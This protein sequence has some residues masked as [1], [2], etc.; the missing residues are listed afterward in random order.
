MLDERLSKEQEAAAR[1]IIA[2][3][4]KYDLNDDDGVLD[5]IIFEMKKNE[6]QVIIQRGLEAQARYIVSRCGGD[7][8]KEQQD[9]IDEM[10]MDHVPSGDVVECATCR[11][12]LFKDKAILQGQ[13]WFCP[14]C[15]K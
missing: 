15:Q 12:Q 5:D 9:S 10:L 11:K 14:A 3:M 6:A 13:T 8:L 4:A 7:A 1:D 2:R